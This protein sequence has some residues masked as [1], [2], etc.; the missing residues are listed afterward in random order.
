MHQKALL[1]VNRR[2]KPRDRELQKISAGIVRKPLK[3]EQGRAF[4]QL[5]GLEIRFQQ[6]QRRTYTTLAR[7]SCCSP[8]VRLGASEIAA[9]GS[10]PTAQK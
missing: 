1:L 5:A 10:K 4:I 8:P 9:F 7:Q 2:N 6:R 3:F